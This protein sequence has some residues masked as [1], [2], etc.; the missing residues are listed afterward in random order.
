ML[1]TQ[2]KN[3]ENSHKSL[4]LM[5]NHVRSFSTVRDN[6][7]WPTIISNMLVLIVPY[8]L[9]LKCFWLFLPYI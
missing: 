5:T 3:K 8:F 7:H 2:P 6:K 1:T 9:R 4:Y